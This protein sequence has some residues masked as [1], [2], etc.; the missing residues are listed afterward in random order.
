MIL[1]RAIMDYLFLAEENGSIPICAVTGTNGKTTVTRMIGHILALNGL[2]VGMTTTDGII[3]NDECIVKGYT[4][5]PDSARNVLLDPQVE[6]CGFGT[7][8][9]R[10][11]TR[12]LSL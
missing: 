4:I 9:R 2:S 10:D 3:I 11:N 8:Q 6:V 7:G 5:G 1:P 12:R